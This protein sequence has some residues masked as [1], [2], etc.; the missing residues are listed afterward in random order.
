MVAAR[1]RR[2]RRAPLR[3]VALAFAVLGGLAG[4]SLVDGVRSL[5]AA[6]HDALRATHAFEAGRL[7]AA[8]RGYGD[9]AGR[10]RRASRSL[11]LLDGGLGWLPVASSTLAL[12]LAEARAG[13][14]AA[15]AAAELASLGARLHARGD[16]LNTGPLRATEAALATATGELERALRELERTDRGTWTPD[17]LARGRATLLAL[18]STLLE[19]LAAAHATAALAEPGR[20]YL[21]VLEN[22]VELRAT[23][24]LIGAW[25]LV[26][27]E[28]DTVRLLRL[29]SN[30]RLPRPRSAVASPA[31]YRARYA[32]FGADRA[33]VNANMS[34]DF[35]TT[36]RILLGLWRAATGERLDGVIAV[37]ALALEH[38][39]ETIGPLRA[40]GKTLTPA[41]FRSEVLV[42]AYARPTAGRRHMLLSAARAGWRRMREGVDPLAL[43]RA[44]SVAAAKGHVRLFAVDRETQKSLARARLAGA[45]A[46]SAGDHLLIVRQNAGGN[47]LDYYLHTT[48]AQSI[49]LDSRGGA[50]SRL[51]IE[52]RNDAPTRGLPPYAVGVL[53]P[54]RIAGT[55]RTYVSVYA[56]STAELVR[57]RAG[58]TR[59]AESA[60]E[61][62]R[63][64]FS[65]FEDVP[66]RSTRKATLWLAS[67]NVARR[68]GGDWSYRLDL[69][70][71]PELNPRPLAVT[72]ALPPGARL[73]TASGPSAQ[74]G[75]SRVRFN[76]VLDHDQSIAV[77][78]C[79]CR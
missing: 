35:P 7:T 69:E 41:T 66:P 72:I 46:R 19:R 78:Y 61:R 45:L 55:N 29:A 26:T 59:T 25:G 77:A 3:G 43:V 58:A 28:R 65:W 16:V 40:A 10:F 9:A 48:L 50:R 42:E 57:F 12:A 36:A 34:P 27:T 53:V 17:A 62:D 33:W 76:T 2:K 30:V 8:S 67:P 24:G 44:L 22:P 18:G 79:F 5:E 47:K 51:S 13:D 20:T 23:G 37:D 4:A 32:R 14:A 15:S 74:V 31:D 38:L 1:V 21:L 6:R 70:A 71:Q 60:R 64:V 73:V 11:R 52:L 56:A 68:R 39:L 75:R 63:R 54:G 49:E